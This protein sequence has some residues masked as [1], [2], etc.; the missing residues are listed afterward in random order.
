[1]RTYIVEHNISQLQN[2]M[3]RKVHEF[4]NTYENVGFLC[5]I[6]VAIFDV[7]LETFKTPLKVIEYLAYTAINV[8]GAACFYDCNFKDALF[9]AQATLNHI[10]ITPVA[11]VMAPLKLI[12]QVF[13]IALD[14]EDVKSINYF[15][16]LGSS[17][18]RLAQYSN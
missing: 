3:Y 9:N 17:G 1:M 11:V 5:A 2:D 13:A 8:F 6:P 10:A 15:Q 14:P 4:A 16:A 18:Y 7:S 12:Y